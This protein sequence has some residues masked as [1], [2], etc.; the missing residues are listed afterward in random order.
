MGETVCDNGKVG[1]RNNAWW[2]KGG[3]EIKQVQ[4]QEIDSQTHITHHSEPGIKSQEL[5]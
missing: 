1:G 5:N 4:R 3:R 2:R